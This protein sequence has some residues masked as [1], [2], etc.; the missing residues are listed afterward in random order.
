[1]SIRFLFFLFATIFFHPPIYNSIFLL[2]ITSFFKITKL[3]CSCLFKS[4]FLH[5]IKKYI[6]LQNTFH[7]ILHFSPPL[8]YIKTLPFKIHLPL[9]WKIASLHSTVHF[10]LH[11]PPLFS[12]FCIFIWRKPFHFNGRG[13]WIILWNVRM[14]CWKG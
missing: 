10:E 14:Y 12:S 9:S 7:L 5:S 1:M 3:H 6:P 4:A 11:H 13:K 2:F 8:K